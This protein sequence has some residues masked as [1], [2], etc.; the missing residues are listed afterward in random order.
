ML[1]LR[2]V[3]NLLPFVFVP[4]LL[5]KVQFDSRRQRL[6]VELGTH[7]QIESLP[8]DRSAEIPLWNVEVVLLRVD[9]LIGVIY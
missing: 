8:V 4:Y 1:S 7:T 6:V 3:V 5:G 2:S 9:N